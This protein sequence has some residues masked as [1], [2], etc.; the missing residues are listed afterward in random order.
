M[1][2]MKPS[3]FSPQLLQLFSRIPWS[4][5]IFRWTVPL[6]K[7]SILHFI[8]CVDLHE[9][10]VGSFSLTLLT[11]KQKHNEMRNDTWHNRPYWC[12]CATVCGVT[13]HGTEQ[14]FLWQREVEHMETKNLWSDAKLWSIN[15]TL[16]AERM[17][18][19]LS[20][21][22][23]IVH[24]GRATGKTKYFPPNALLHKLSLFLSSPR[25][26]S[27]SLVCWTDIEVSVNWNSDTY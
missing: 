8:N 25:S 14:A 26:R 27:C 20:K 12:Y 18:C 19:L 22:G 5:L 23:S 2:C 6:I 4:S 3:G 17:S 10:G 11:N 7:T 15:T 1:S 21:N 24:T 9:N 13:L 16:R